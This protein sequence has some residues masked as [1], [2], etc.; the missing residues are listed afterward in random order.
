MSGA[1]PQPVEHLSFDEGVA[2]LG[3]RWEQV[4]ARLAA[5]TDRDVQLVAVSKGHGV[6][7]VRMALAAGLVELG[8]NYAQELLAKH[9]DLTTTAVD[10]SPSP[11]WHFVG[12]LQRNKVRSLAGLVTLWHTVDS[13]RLADEIARRDPGA[14]VLVQVDLARLEGRG[15]IAPAGAADLVRHCVGAGL[16]VQGLMGVGPPGAPDRGRR[17][18]GDLVSL[19]D[20]LDLEQRCIGM[21]G[22]LEVAAAA[23]ATMVRVGTDLFGARPP[24]NGVPVGTPSG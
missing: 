16:D 6:R 23:G 21:S 9:H 13:A 14:R 17:A 19:A 11:R 22:D 5:A 20:R 15:G 2:E 18:F 4:R 10:G 3:R 24:R 12:R 1:T 7:A 8:E